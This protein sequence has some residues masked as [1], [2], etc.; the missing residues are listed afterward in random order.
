MIDR[1]LGELSTQASV[2]NGS[3]PITSAPARS[4]ATVAKTVSK[5]RSLLACRDMELQPEAAAGRCLRLS[6]YSFGSGEWS[7]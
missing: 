3:V 2:K 7:G 4:W 1:Q 5:S 6:R